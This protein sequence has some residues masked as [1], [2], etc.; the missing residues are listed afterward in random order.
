MIRLGNGKQPRRMTLGAGVAVT[1]KPLTFAL[2]RAAVHSAERQAREVASELGLIE[3]AGGSIA[4]IPSPHDAEGMRGLRDQFLLQ[5]LARHAI[6]A[7]EGIGDADG[8]P[9]PVTPETIDALIRDH[10]LLAERFE[11]EYL[12]EITEWIAEG[13]ASGAAPTG[14]SAAAPTT[15]DAAPMPTSPAPAACP[16]GTASSVPTGATNH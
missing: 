3:A 13:N 6:A 5:A 2:Y 8:A 11:V 14:T 12:R 4:D 10:P 9:A 1:V 7:W 15:A 16:D